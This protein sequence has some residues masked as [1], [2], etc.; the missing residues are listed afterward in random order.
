MNTASNYQW[1]QK[2]QNLHSTHK[3]TFQHSHSPT[4][5]E[6]N[7]LLHNSSPV[8]YLQ[9][10]Q[11]DVGQMTDRIVREID[12]HTSFTQNEIQTQQY[13]NPNQIS[14]LIHI[15]KK[16]K[17]LKYAKDHDHN[18]FTTI[19][20]KMKLF[21]LDNSTTCFD[22]YRCTDLILLKYMIYLLILELNQDTSNNQ[23]QSIPDQ[24]QQFHNMVKDLVIIIYEIIEQIKSKQHISTQIDTL[25]NQLTKIQNTFQPQLNSSIKTIKKSSHH[26]G[27]S[28][29]NLE[30]N[31]TKFHKNILATEIRTKSNH[32][33][34]DGQQKI[35]KYQID[36]LEQK[37]KLITSLN[38][39]ILKLQNNNKQSIHS[40]TELNTQ[41]ESIK[42][43]LQSKIDEF[44]QLRKSYEYLKSSN[45]ICQEEKEQYFNLSHNFEQENLK[46]KQNLEKYQ[47]AHDQIKTQFDQY[48]NETYSSYQIQCTQLQQIKD[49]EI[50]QLKIELNGKSSIINQLLEDALFF[51]KQ[52][53]QIVERIVTIKQEEFGMDM[54]KLQKEILFQQNTVNAKL[55]A[56][57]SYSEN[58]MYDSGQEFLLQSQLF[59]KMVNKTSTIKSGFHQQNKDFEYLNSY[60]NQFELMHMLL[61][62]SQVLEEF[63]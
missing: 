38:D 9:L 21:C 34:N 22:F 31:K 46:L 49:N 37:S 35:I 41:T 44:E 36:E 61:A 28:S 29:C 8:P 11:Y 58:I 59:N 51:G 30:N 60:N 10:K 54:Q 15:D 23:Q 2:F 26:R 43:Q 27:F 16:L 48:Q 57:Q 4:P 50:K 7:Q 20:T 33:L 14:S 55:N 56:I 47:T 5:T 19:L 6:I 13:S 3:K 45:K 24:K 12:K 1:L 25:N 17:Q 32:Y 40:I 63:L 52:Y 39:Q 53:K 62:Q 18:I 42:S